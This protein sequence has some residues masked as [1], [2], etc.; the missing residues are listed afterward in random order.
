[1]GF[2]MTPMALPGTTGNSSPRSS[3]T[4]C[5]PFLPARI[6]YAGAD[7]LTRNVTGVT[8]VDD[9]IRAGPDRLYR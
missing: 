5:H 1:M 3:I 2:G 8:Q 7:Q 4:A 6:N 9:F